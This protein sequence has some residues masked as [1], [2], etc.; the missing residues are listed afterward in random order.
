MPDMAIA[1]DLALWAPEVRVEFVSYAMGAAT[2]RA[3]GYAVVDLEFGEE[4]PYL[5]VL[6]AATRLIQERR[7]DVVVAHE[8]FAV[9]PAARGLGVPSVFVLDFFPRSDSLWSESL[10]HADEVI[11]VERQGIFGEPP[12][13]KGKVRYVG[14]ILRPLVVGPGDR[15][16]CRDVLGLAANAIVVSVIPGAW[17]TEQRAPIAEVVAEAFESLP[18]QSKH[19]VW[20][21]GRDQEL[22]SARLRDVPGAIVLKEYSPIEKVM[23]A[24]DVVVTKGNRGTILEV[25]SLGVPSVSL[26]YNLNPVDE[27]IV[28]RVPSNV[29]LHARGIDAPLLARVLAESFARQRGAVVPPSLDVAESKAA[30]L[31]A[32]VLASFVERCAHD[33]AGVRGPERPISSGASSLVC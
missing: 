32:R 28:L 8:E 24:S 4:A 23:V 30:T 9:L 17:A 14:P 16:P 31:A 6:I 29:A 22:L 2:F 10:K 5:D 20:I 7:P 12:Q 15:A 13:L 18:G 19:L 21:A 1:S 27:A 26:T 25:A 3:C 11:F 33:A